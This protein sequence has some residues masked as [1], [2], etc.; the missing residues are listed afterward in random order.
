M[1]ALR[2]EEQ[3]VRRNEDTD[4]LDSEESYES[5]DDEAGARRRAEQREARRRAKLQAGADRMRRVEER[6][7]LLRQKEAALF[8]CSDE[9][10][11]GESEDASEEAP[12]VQFAQLETPAGRLEFVSTSIR[13]LF[14]TTYENVDDLT[15]A[16][17]VTYL[18]AAIPPD[19]HEDFDTTEV[20]KAAMALHARREFVF[21]GDIL[22]LP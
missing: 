2:Q 21:Q 8:T 11:E 22:R 18:N 7:A 13:Y 9:D 14:R 5:G 4:E 16:A 12:A 3:S 15:I 6:R 20:T 19:K 10:A 1:E 17:L